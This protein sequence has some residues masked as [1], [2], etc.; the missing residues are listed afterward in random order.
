LEQNAKIPWK[1]E[2]GAKHY[3]SGNRI[4]RQRHHRNGTGYK[5]LWKPAGGSQEPLFD[6]EI[7]EQDRTRT[8]DALFEYLLN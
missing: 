4:Q 6:L 8:V 7:T 3:G 2:Q 1:Q 5:T